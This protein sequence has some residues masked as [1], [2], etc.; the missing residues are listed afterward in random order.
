MKEQLYGMI[1]LI[2]PDYIIPPRVELGN[3]K[4]GG[5]LS[6]VDLLTGQG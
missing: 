3:T 4:Q 1:S 6:T 2:T 5:R